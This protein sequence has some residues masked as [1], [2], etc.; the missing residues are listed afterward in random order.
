[1]YLSNRKQRNMKN[2]YLFIII[3]ALALLIFTPSCTS[4]YYY[5]ALNTSTPYFEKVDNGDFLYENDSLWIAYCFKGEDAPIEITVGNKLDIPLYVDWARSALILDGKAYSYHTDKVDHSSATQTT[6]YGRYIPGGLEYSESFTQGSSTLPKHVSFIPPKAMIN[7]S[8]LRLAARF[9]EID[10]KEYSNAKLVSRDGQNFDIKRIDYDIDSSPLAFS[11]YL[12]IY[13]K[14]D[15]I[16]AY[17]SDFYIT[18]LLRTK[19]RPNEL[20]NDMADRGDIFYQEKRAN[21][22]GWYILANVAVVTTSVALDVIL[23]GDEY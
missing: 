21:N 12:T 17:T 16:R 19:L 14:P 8:S 10:K 6:S 13:S 5:T 9:D 1:M 11:S 22:T 15:K 18:T 23:Y 3:G 7:H 20:P 2:R 4:T